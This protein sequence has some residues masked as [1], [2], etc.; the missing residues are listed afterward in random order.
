MV[1]SLTSRDNHSVHN[2]H[3]FL[4]GARK[5]RKQKYMTPRPPGARPK[6]SILLSSTPL[7][8]PLPG[9]LWPELMVRKMGSLKAMMVIRNQAD[10]R[11]IEKFLGFT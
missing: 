8:I 4:L 7:P 2:S 1:L 9:T 5:K 10:I 3:Y 11:S 6:Q